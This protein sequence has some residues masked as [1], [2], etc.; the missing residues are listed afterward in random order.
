VVGARGYLLRVEGAQPHERDTR[1][2]TPAVWAIAA[3]AAVAA[4]F[5]S[6]GPTGSDAADVVWKALFA[7]VVTAAGALAGRLTWIIAAGI[8]AAAVVGGDAVVVAIAIVALALALVGAFARS[9]PPVV[10]AV[11]L[12]LVVQVLL[13]LPEFGFTGTTAIVAAVATLPVLASAY[14]RLGRRARRWVR[15]GAVVAVVVFVLALIPVGVSAIV[16]VREADVAVDE[17]QAW[18]DAARVGEQTQAIGHLDASH[19]SFSEIEQATGAPWMWPARVLPVIGPQVETI[20]RMAQSGTEVTEFAGRAARIATPENLRLDQGQIDVGLL[21]ALREPLADAAVALDRS[22]DRLADIDRTWLVPI[23]QTKVEEFEAQVDDATDETDL[24]VSALEVA[25]GLLGAD[26]PRT[27][28]V[29]FASPAETRELGGF[30]GNAAILTAS[31][32]HLELERVVRSRELNEETFKLPLT[33]LARIAELGFPDRYLDYE[34]WRYWQNVTGTPDF[35]TVSAMVR[36]LAP[37][38]I[39][40]PVDGVMYVDPDGLAGLLQLTGPIEIEGL[41]E[42]IGPAN[43]SDFLLREQYVRYPETS[44][45]ADFLEEVAR[46]TFERL[47]SAQL[48]GPRSIGDALGPAV[49]G[50]HLQIWTFAED[51]QALFDRLE[52]T[53]RLEPSLAGDD[54]LVTTANANPNKIDAYLHREI[55]Y[56]ATLDPSTGALEATVTV[57]LLNDAPLDLSD[58]VIGNA[59]GEP[60]GS[61]R[62]LLS[63]Y[64]G[65]GVRGAELDGQPLPYET[66]DEYGLRRVVTFV[67]VPPG[68][69]IQVRFVLAGDL[70]LDPSGDGFSVHVRSPALVHADSFE[71]RLQSP[72]AVVGRPELTTA[73][74]LPGAPE[75]APGSARFELRGLAVVRFPLE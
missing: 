66:H 73:G 69:R 46:T 33:E 63:L 74:P 43:V 8:A 28:L 40:R 16:T 50:G 20:H 44:A 34:P 1:R 29:L 53:G 10:G 31:N 9:I 70:A 56:D 6:A 13:R 67:T 54:V 18:L 68:G 21:N 27:Y 55:A 48:P 57:D 61:N 11:V 35:P 47:T 41:D 30:V 38:A 17:S 42:L 15:R 25:P 4:A 23:L 5:A 60:Q 32:G 19:A 72:E 7:A 62:M 52:A 36:Q 58:Y 14:V 39:G 64:T 45:R 71:V 51:E 12:G 37:E 3:G 26:G 2:V 22:R 75:Q 59:N 49:D 65:L 24:A